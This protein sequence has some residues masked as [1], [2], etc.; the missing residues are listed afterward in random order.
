VIEVSGGSAKVELGQ[1]I[2]ATCR[3]S[4]VGETQND[5]ASQAATGK[6]DLTSLTSML[7][8]RWKSGAVAESSKPDEIRAGQVR[9][10]RITKLDQAAKKI[11]VEVSS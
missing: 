7:Q 6:A 9:S 4:S 2:H 3:I 5:S 10:F 8:A 11:E 1:G